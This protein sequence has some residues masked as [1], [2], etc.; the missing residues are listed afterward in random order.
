[1]K[2]KRS[3]LPYV[4]GPYSPMPRGTITGKR[5]LYLVLNPGPQNE[6][7]RRIDQTRPFLIS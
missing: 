6:R 7:T 1:M 2:S 4:P 5:S 3:W